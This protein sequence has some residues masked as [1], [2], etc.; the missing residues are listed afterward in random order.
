VKL[1]YDKDPFE[2]RAK[3]EEE[4]AF[5]DKSTPEW[6]LPLSLSVFG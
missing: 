1:V 6:T 5:K 2:M 3:V 4:D